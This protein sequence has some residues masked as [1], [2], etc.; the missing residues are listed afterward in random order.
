[1]LVSVYMPTKNRAALLQQAVD[2]VLHQ[3]H[4]QLELLI[5]DDG[6][7]D[8]TP[9]TLQRLA[10]LD[11]RVRIFRNEVSRGAPVSRNIAI[12]AARGEWITGIDDD[13]TFMPE[14]LQALLAAWQLLEL[15]GASFC[16]LYTQDLYD[17]GQT[18]VASSKRGSLNWQ[19]LF[20]FNAIGN[21]LFTRTSIL[22]AVGG[23]DPEMPAWQDLDLFIRILK[24]Y[25]AARLLDA[26]L[27][28]LS[29]SDRPDRISQSKKARIV[30]AFERVAAKH[31]EVSG[32]QRQLLYLQIFGK[33]YGHRPDLSDA[34]RFFGDGWHA[35]TAK[36]FVARVL[37]RG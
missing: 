17:D 33:L 16:S 29:V 31:P 14:R 37:A 5:V 23:F 27:Y 11:P 30:E 34:R 10:A 6:S 1:M 2:S 22:R 35:G 32:R 25:G 18:Q 15:T 9:A 4:H 3:T 21:Q 19:D 26:P 7:T 12:E 36:R 13:D 8:D 24:R 28:T 20:E